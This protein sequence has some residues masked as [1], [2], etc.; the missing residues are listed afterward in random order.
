MRLLLTLLLL[1]FAHQ[2]NAQD[3]LELSGEVVEEVEHDRTLISKPNWLRGV[4]IV[5]DI[6]VKS[7][8][9]QILAVLPAEWSE[10]CG[11]VT[12]IGGDYAASV[13]FEPEIT[14]DKPRLAR[15][16]FE[17]RKSFPP[18]ANHENSGIVLE[19]G[20]CRDD[21]DAQSKTPDYVAGFWNVERKPVTDDDGNVQVLMNMNVA[22]AEK[23][24]AKAMLA[25][26]ALAVQCWKLTVPEALAFN[27]Q[28]RI[29]MPESM[30][31]LAA[32]TPISFDYQRFYRGRLAEPHV[33]KIYAGMN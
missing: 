27:F 33:A 18:D 1:A 13:Y 25:D 17:P 29:S 16:D 31:K 15:L 26:V 30:L 22:R 23:L 5:G 3:V 21:Q 14:S 28:C 2:S 19:R 9:P 11:K 24:I 20:D 12:T 7:D 8:R 4:H 10:F 6:P 32:M